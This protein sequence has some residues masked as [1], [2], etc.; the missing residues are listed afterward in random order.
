M[1]IGISMQIKPP[2]CFYVFGSKIIKQFIHFFINSG[3]NSSTHIPMS[4][5]GAL[6]SYCVSNAVMLGVVVKESYSR[7]VWH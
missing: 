7:P 4:S 2:V 6:I 5:K 3:N 1:G